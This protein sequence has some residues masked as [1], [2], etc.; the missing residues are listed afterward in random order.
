MKDN[1]AKLLDAID[2]GEFTRRGFLGGTAAFG[3]AVAVGTS[4]SSTAAFAQEPK[5]GGVLK[6]GIGGGETTDT[7]DPALAD[8]SAQFMATRLWGDSLLGVTP[9]GQIENR[10]A[11]THSSNPDATVWTFKIREGVK[12]HDGSEMTVEDVIATFKRHSD[13]NSKSGALGSLKGISSIV[14][15]GQ[16]V[17]FTLESG[18]ADLPFLLSG[19]NLLIQ[20]NG[21]FDA[22]AAGV[23]T[24][25]YKVVSS[26]P[27]VRYVFE[28]NADYWDTTRGHYDSIE[29]IVI[30]DATARNSALQA[31]QVHMI[32]RVSPKVADLLGRS[33]NVTVRNTSG[34]AHYEFVMLVDTAPFDNKDLRLA[35]KYAINRQEMVEK[36]LNGYG[37]V[38]NDIPINAAYPLFDE[39]LP[40][41]DF[42]LE[43]AAEHYKK[44]GHDG[45]PIELIVAEAAFPGATDAAA[46]W[47]QTCQQ[48]G[49]PLTVKKVPDD[50]YWDNVWQKM[51]FCAN[52]WSGR[53]VQD[54]MYSTAYTS[55]SAWNDTHFY[56]EEF[57]ALIV[58]ARAELDQ[59]KRA[60]LY[61]KIAHLLWEEGGAVVPMFN[62]LIDAHTDAIAGWEPDPNFELMAGYA[63][64]KTWMA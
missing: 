22:P 62:D 60:E 64:L 25:A 26:D 36:I 35:L 29:M 49:I 11:E 43:K 10:I 47:Q 37:S 54:Q 52:Y 2:S 44:S 12:F 46:L 34:R 20:P 7:L 56:N 32:N 53:P 48:A 63:P 30:N 27:G 41:R 40:Q 6:L 14:A 9:D 39:S 42:D 15:D 17:I 58:Q 31:G 16:N 55:S 33:P 18:N 59:E 19:Y 28:K 1:L 38:G 23:G 57:D 3:A 13:E 5:K 61:S 8:N 45:S 21:G 24:G 50:G 51:P 4:I